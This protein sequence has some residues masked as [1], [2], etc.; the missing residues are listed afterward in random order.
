MTQGTCEAVQSGSLPL[1]QSCTQLLK[2]YKIIKS[3]IGIFG[4]DTSLIALCFS[5]LA[6]SS[7]VH[8]VF[9]IF[10][11]YQMSSLIILPWI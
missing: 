7:T 9:L 11:Y 2:K 6:L 1:R 4:S 5:H 3:N 10:Y 8:P